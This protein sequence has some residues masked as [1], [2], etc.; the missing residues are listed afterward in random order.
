[1]AELAELL[2]GSEFAANGHYADV[3][4]VVEP[5]GTNDIYAVEIGQMAQKAQ[6]LS[7]SAP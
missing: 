5:M 2:R 6:S 4:A 7:P 1:M 3:L